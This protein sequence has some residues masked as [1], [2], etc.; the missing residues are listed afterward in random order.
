MTRT[1]SR[2]TEKLHLETFVEILGKKMSA[3]DKLEL[4]E[5]LK[6]NEAISQLINGRSLSELRHSYD[7][8]TDLAELV[9]KLVNN[10]FSD[11]VRAIDATR[12]DNT[13]LSRG[14]AQ[15]KIFLPHVLRFLTDEYDEICSTVIPCLT[16]LLGLMRKKTKSNSSFTAENAFMLPMILD[17]VIA[18]VKYDETAVWGNESTQ[19]DEAEFQDLRKRLHIL[20]Q[21]VAAV[22]ENMYTEKITDVV[23]STIESFNAQ[24]GQLD[25]RDTELALHQLY[26]FGEL[27]MK[28]GGL[29]SKTRPISRTAEQLIGMMFKLM[30]TG[31]FSSIC[32]HAIH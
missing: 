18:K 5:V 16:D 30:E 4:I 1:E 7:Y 2:K 28:N 27:A 31:K 25:W 10:T 32:T 17:G 24:R 6:V 20:Q 14:N 21:A 3:S 29:Y 9:A 26:L 22:D 11:I 8:D 15:L 12:D 13:V 23:V 19:T